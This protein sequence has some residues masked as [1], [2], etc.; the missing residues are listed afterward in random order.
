MQTSRAYP[1]EWATPWPGASVAF[2]PVTSSTM[3]DARALAEAGCPTGT[4]AAAGRQEKGRGRAPGRTWLSVP[5]EA[6]AA[7]VVL[8]IPELGFPLRE[9]TL[10]AGLAAARGIEEAAGIAVQVKWPNDILAAVA[11]EQSPRK[12]AGIL[13]E[14]RGDVALVG[15]GVNCGQ[16]SFPPEIAA[17][18]GS[19]RQACGRLVAPPVVLAAVLGHLKESAADPAW[20]DALGSRLYRRGELVRVE[21][22]GSG[23]SVEG[24]LLG[25]SDEGGL[26]LR[27]S[28]G[29]LETVSQGELGSSP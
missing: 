7:T 9:L 5:G 1:A 29:R 24:I 21:L 8:R 26:V 18:A 14:A 11:G 17:T 27:L 15:I 16:D 23:R 10:R 3:D 19:L 4:V 6:L 2:R 25:V 22:L 20:K 12:V 28:G 13:C